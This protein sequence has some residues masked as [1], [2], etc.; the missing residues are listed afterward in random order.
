LSQK[1]ETAVKNEFSREVDRVGVV[2]ALGGR[3][4]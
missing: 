4:G 3:A 1:T 2:M